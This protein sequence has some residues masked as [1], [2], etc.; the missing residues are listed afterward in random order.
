MPLAKLTAARQV[1]L[2]RAHIALL[3]LFSRRGLD[4][5]SYVTKLF[6]Q[7]AT[8]HQDDGHNSAM[9]FL[10]DGFLEIFTANET[11][12]GGGGGEHLLFD[13]WL[14]R[15][16]ATC[17]NSDQERMLDC[18]NAIVTKSADVAFA[19]NES[20]GRQQ[21][22]LLTA[23]YATML[24]YVLQTFVRTDAS[25]GIAELAANMCL[26]CSFNG[27]VYTFEAVFAQFTESCVSNVQ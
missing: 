14:L 10:A 22:A 20:E 2:T 16:L 1:S 18:V 23:L 5:T 12:G 19:L 3:V 25:R 26:G 21:C 7:L 15:Y 9:R 24:P 4:I 11:A 27:S 8:I 17:S 6:E 13:T